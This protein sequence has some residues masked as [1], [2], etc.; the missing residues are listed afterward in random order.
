MRNNCRVDV[1]DG[2]V[3]VVVGIVGMSSFSCWCGGSG[4]WMV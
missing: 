2:N 4:G 1:E 3:V